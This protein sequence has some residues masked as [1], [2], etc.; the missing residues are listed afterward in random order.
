MYPTLNEMGIREFGKEFFFSFL[1]ALGV[2]EI[3]NKSEMDYFLD[4]VG[5]QPGNFF[6]ISDV[7][8]FEC[9]IMVI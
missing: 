5:P 4:R 6:W 8:N 2:E 1:F 9:A 3:E 7:L